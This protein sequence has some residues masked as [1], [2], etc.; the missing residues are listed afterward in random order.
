MKHISGSNP[1]IEYEICHTYMLKN[2]CLNILN[3]KG[4]KQPLSSQVIRLLGPSGESRRVNEES[5]LKMVYHYTYLSIP[6]GSVLF[7]EF[8]DAVYKERI[9][10]TL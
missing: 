5:K 1:Y 7:R 6:I 3:M 4:A 10:I 8:T 2:I 9:I